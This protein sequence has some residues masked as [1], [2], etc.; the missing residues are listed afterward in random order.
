MD[1][2]GYIQPVAVALCAFLLISL[3]YLVWRRRRLGSGR[4]AFECYQRK[5]G[6]PTKARWHHGIVRYRRDAVVWFPLLAFGFTP[7]ITVPRLR[8]KIGRQRRPTD[9]E[10]AQLFEGQAIVQ[11][12]GDS[13]QAWEWAMAPSAAHGL[14]AWAESAPPGEGQYG[15]TRAPGGGTGK[16][17]GGK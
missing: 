13:G 15:L 1:W 5:S 12:T 14:L 7:G 3:A 6:L 17:K 9:V 10:R 4:G 2:A 8:V 11:V 16:R